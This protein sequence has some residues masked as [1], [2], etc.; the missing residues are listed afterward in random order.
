VYHLP[1][2]TATFSD[3]FKNVKLDFGLRNFL[4]KW[5]VPWNVIQEFNDVNISY[6]KLKC[7]LV[8]NFSNMNILYHLEPFFD[9]IIT[10]NLNLVNNYIEK[11]QPNTRFILK[12]KFIECGHCDFVC[13][14]E[15]NQ[16]INVDYISKLQYIVNGG[17]RGR[18]NLEDLIIEIT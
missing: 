11:E 1:S 14:I 3:E 5:H 2:S 10:D 15:E 9:T 6:K 7:K 18:Y 8:M 16:S 13:Y 17:E 12:N 4:R